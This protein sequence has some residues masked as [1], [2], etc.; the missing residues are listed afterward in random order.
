[1]AN[2]K[3]YKLVLWHGRKYHTDRQTRL[4]KKSH[5]ENSPSGESAAQPKE[6]RPRQRRLNLAPVSEPQPPVIIEYNV[7]SELEKRGVGGADARKLLASLQPGQP[8]LDQL[9]YG[10]LQIEQAKGKIT[11][12][13]G[14][15]ISLLQRNIPIPS[16]FD[17][18]F[19]GRRSPDA[20]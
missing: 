7:V 3:N 16:T 9:E 15:Y 5:L 18:C 10:D 8:V 20:F 6:H 11:N 13:P 17:R 12:P 4:E 19:A 2:R 1:M 14:F